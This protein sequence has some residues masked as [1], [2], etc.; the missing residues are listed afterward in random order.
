MEMQQTTGKRKRRTINGDAVKKP[1]KRQRRDT[2]TSAHFNHSIMV[3]QKSHANAD[4]SGAVAT[5]TDT[6]ARNISALEETSKP[7][8]ENRSRKSRK[9]LA[10]HPDRPKSKHTSSIRE[11]ATGPLIPPNEA[12][13]RSTV[14]SSYIPDEPLIGTPTPVKKRRNRR[15]KEPTSPYF[16]HPPSH[17]S[18]PPPT[19][20]TPPTP[21]PKRSLPKTS[22]KSKISIIEAPGV[23]P[24][25]P[26]FRPTSENEFGLIQEKLRHEPWKMLVAVIFLNVTTAKMALPL[27]GQFFERW[28]DSE[29]LSKGTATRILNF[30][31]PLPRDPGE[32]AFISLA[33]MCF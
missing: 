30:V 32:P 3:R 18:S 21:I 17:L 26:H 14:Q 20:P 23:L 1:R 25:L 5:D 7:V 31:S 29:S 10:E 16:P 12:T 22:S 9:A 4:V 6:V 8:K 19:P 13:T 28:P 27:L 24:S 11:T 2:A 33:I 15:W